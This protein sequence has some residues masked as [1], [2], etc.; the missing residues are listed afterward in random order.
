MAKK[1]NPHPM[2][3]QQHTMDQFKEKPQKE[4]DFSPETLEEFYSGFSETGNT[5]DIALRMLFIRSWFYEVS[6]FDPISGKTLPT[7]VSTFVDKISDLDEKEIITRKE[8]RVYRILEHTSA[9]V[10]H[11]IGHIRSKIVRDHALLPIYAAREMDMVSVQWLARK[12]GRN[13]REKLSGKPYIMAVRRQNSLDTAENRLLKSFLQKMDKILVLREENLGDELEIHRT[14]KRW[15]KDEETG[16]IGPWINLVP[17]NTLL[18]DKYYQKILRGWEWLKAL[19]ETIRGDFRNIRGEF[20]AIL[21]WEILARMSRYDFFRLIQKPVKEISLSCFEIKG[22]ILDKKYK[23]WGEFD[24]SLQNNR[25]EIKSARNTLILTA[26]EVNIDISENNTE[27]KYFIYSYA[28]IRKYV[29]EIFVLLLGKKYEDARFRT[30]SPVGDTPFAVIDLYNVKPNFI[31]GGGTVQELPFALLAQIFDDGMTADCSK[32]TAL[33]F[34]GDIKTLSI[35]NLFFNDG[36]FTSSEKNSAAMDFTGRLKKHIQT[37]KLTYIVPDWAGD[38]DLE[39]IRRGINFYYGQSISVPQSIAAVVLWFQKYGKKFKTDTV[40]LVIDV[41]EGKIIVTPIRSYKDKELADRIPETSGICWERHPNII[42]DSQYTQDNSG[43]SKEMLKIFGKDY[44]ANDNNKISIYENESKKWHHLPEQKEKLLETFKIKPVVSQ[45][46]ITTELYKNKIFHEGQTF[47]YIVLDDIT[48]NGSGPRKEKFKANELLEGALLL[49]ERQGRTGG[50]HLWKDHL[51]DLVLKT[52]VVSVDLVSEKTPPINPQIGKPETI[53]PI[54]EED[55]KNIRLPVMTRD[56]LSFDLIQGR[57]SN[58]IKYFAFLKSPAFPLK[59]EV[60]CDL[61]LTYT[62]GEAIPYNL[63]FRPQDP[64]KAG[65][66]SVEVK[67]LTKDELPEPE[68]LMPPF[69]KQKTWEEF[70]HY[71]K[72]DGTGE[73]NLIDWSINGLDKFYRETLLDKDEEIK[74][75]KKNREEGIYQ[76]KKQDSKGDFFCKATNENEDVFCHSKCFIEPFESFNFIQGTKLYFTKIKGEKWPWDGEYIT[77]TEKY[78]AG[79]EN[80]VAEI[81]EQRNINLTDSQMNTVYNIL[82]KKYFPLTT[83]FNNGRSLSEPG[84]PPELKI[85]YSASEYALT[86][87]EDGKISSELRDEIIF[88]LSCLHKDM[89]QGAAKYLTDLAANIEKIGD[90]KVKSRHARNIAYAIGDASLDWQKELL[91]MALNNKAQKIET[92]TSLYMLAIAFWRNKD[93]VFSLDIE[94]IHRLINTL[95]FTFEK[96]TNR[97]ADDKKRV[98]LAGALCKNMELLLALLRVRTSEKKILIPREKTAEWFIEQLVKTQ[99]SLDDAGLEI[100]SFLEFK[101][102]KPTNYKKIPDLIYALKLYLTGDD[103]ANTIIINSD[104]GNDDSM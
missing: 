67:W 51:P 90:P 87:L 73:S 93:L 58:T 55:F 1:E 98:Y 80:K 100:R 47:E 29:M 17:N 70:K 72:K 66:A 94:R 71:P 42:P 46:Q 21:F 75:M 83:I 33:E 69:P 20:L 22:F 61:H 82:Q 60:I 13:L 62:Y 64:E 103:G 74:K 27:I 34:S 12:P 35:R 48:I 40:F 101:I 57:G 77:Y 97:L 54:K 23:Y 15:L 85:I 99:R 24:I 39:N 95:K 11:I 36:K 10:R 14:I 76:W 65:F 4:I 32:A 84:A 104:F 18:S 92:D 28:E 52:P 68:L 7:D 41:S 49:T 81:V 45:A 79:I 86:L 2:P 91:D 5:R 25:I 78:P 89:P 19:D 44:I 37:N 59:C 38:K 3:K 88:F 16:A 50:I 102:P 96:N 53:H 8:D 6:E 63:Q 56:Y 31:A 9:A 30:E 26:N 43:L